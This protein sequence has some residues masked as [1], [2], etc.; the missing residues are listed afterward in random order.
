[1]FF[2]TLKRLLHFK[3]SFYVI[4]AVFIGVISS[5]AIVFNRA[6]LFVFLLGGRSCNQSG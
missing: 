5:A 6:V 4:I 1:M 3:N 2:K